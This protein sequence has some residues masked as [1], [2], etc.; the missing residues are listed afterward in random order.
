MAVRARQVAVDVLYEI[1]EKQAYSNLQIN[2]IAAGQMDPRELNLFREL[3]YGVLENKLYLD[4]IIRKASN[5]RF[6]RIHKKILEVLRISI[7][8]LYF[9]DRIPDRA[10]VNEGA[11]LARKIGHKGSVSFVNGLLRAV[12]RDKDKFSKIEEK[13]RIKYL[14]IKY[15]HP[16]FMIKRWTDQY[17]FQ[18]A[19]EICK[20]NNKRPS[21]NIRR[22]RLK[23][24]RDDLKRLLEKRGL[25][26]EEGLY[27][28][29][30]LIIKN[31][32]EITEI[33]EFKEGLF[34][35]QDQS[36]MMV[37]QIMDPRPGSSLLDLCSA[38]GGKT[39]HMGEIM[40]NR[41]LI[42]A[43][44]IHEHKLRLIEDNIRRL[45]IEIVK[46]EKADALKKDMEL[47]GKFDYCLLDAP[48]SGTGIIRRKPEIRWNKNEDDI[49]SLAKLQAKMLDIAKDYLK[50]GGVLLYSTCS[51]EKEENQMVVEEFLERNPDFKLLS[52]E[53]YLADNK[54]IKGLDKGYL[55]FLPHKHGTDGFFIS[56]MIKEG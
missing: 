32:Q 54:Q 48:C 56:K 23:I 41:G 30:C 51:I 20:A 14:S 27:A 37:G 11:N 33:E 52:L 47:E 4:H 10:A 50:I 19:E 26:L 9:M 3:V 1:N 15:S 25:V 21:L 42:L 36:S 35:I 6:N 18:E 39:S 31:P 40:A 46:T 34:T 2:K 12:A 22:N 55:Q 45:G 28:E 16:P 5:I 44:D 7:Y 24:S 53:G 38:P 29:D 13:D 49:K 17:G 8:Q 43:R